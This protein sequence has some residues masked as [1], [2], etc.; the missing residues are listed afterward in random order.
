[1]AISNANWQAI[2]NMGYQVGWNDRYK[3]NHP[4]TAAPSNKALCI[5]AAN[6][7]A[8][9]NAGFQKAYGKTIASP[10]PADIP[11]DDDVCPPAATPAT[12]N[13]PPQASTASAGPQFGY[14]AE[15]WGNMYLYWRIGHDLGGS[16]LA[17]QAALCAG[18]GENSFITVGCNNSNHCGTWQLDSTWQAMHAYTDVAYWTT[19]AYQ[20]GFWN[21]GGIISIAHAHPEYSAGYIANMCQGAYGDLSEGGNYYE[22]FAADANRI[23]NYWQ[24][25]SPSVPGA[26][27]PA[28]PPAPT[29]ANSLDIFESY[30]WAGGYEIIWQNAYKGVTDAASAWTDYNSRLVKTDYVKPAAFD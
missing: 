30:N 18:F 6:W 7:N 10:N 2:W 28:Q 4:V 23:Y 22:Q 24:G 29:P 25:A 14:S 8:V 11:H 13:P 19:Y 20:N 17:I 1:M 3:A 27:Q 15:Q 9:Y 16:Y 26:T 12:V 5:S 21:Y